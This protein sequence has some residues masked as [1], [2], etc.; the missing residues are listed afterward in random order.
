MNLIQ[1]EKHTTTDGI[2][3]ELRDFYIDNPGV[4][5]LVQILSG[6]SF[7]VAGGFHAA[8]VAT[9]QSY[10]KER[11]KTYFDE[12]AKGNI[13][14]SEED[15]QNED[16]LHAFFATTKAA[17]ATRNREKIKL[18]AKLFG[19]YCN[20]KEFD[21]ID[22][23]EEWLSILEDISYREFQ[24]LLVLK[25]ASEIKLEGKEKREICYKLISTELQMEKN[26]VEGWLSRIVRTGLC[27]KHGGYGGDYF[28]LKPNFESFLKALRLNDYAIIE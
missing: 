13:D 7:G 28:E 25:K 27:G 16:F 8:L 9:I 11:L 15:I 10:Q 5:F 22:K 1:S 14:L 4:N 17:S 3:D 6:F 2:L 23:Y 20:E 19:T 12:L 21:K 26:E 24:I 18:F